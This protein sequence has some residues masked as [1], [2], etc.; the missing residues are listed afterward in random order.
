MT[1]VPIRE[2]HLFGLLAVG[3]SVTVLLHS[4]GQLAWAPSSLLG[5][6]F[7]YVGF[8]LLWLFA[9]AEFKPY[10]V[11]VWVNLE[12]LRDDFG[13]A[14]Q[15]A[16]GNEP[17]FNSFTF[18]ALTPGAFACSAHSSAESTAYYSTRL[19]FAGALPGGRPGWPGPH[20]FFESRNRG[21]VF[22]V[23]A[24]DDWWP[25]QSGRF[26]PEIPKTLT[27]AGYGWQ[28]VV[29]RVLPSG[30]LP[31]HLREREEPTRVFSLFSWRNKRW[32]TELRKGGW[33]V[34]ENDP[35]TITS[36]YLNVSYNSLG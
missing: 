21:L 31:D 2:L 19:G 11:K 33:T 8:G 32:M 3:A 17:A 27:G 34:D 12:A 23:R 7:T 20:F 25:A 29:L 15:A 30:Y 36:R 4:A 1:Q 14:D 13:S 26:A 16:L 10:V 6:G 28:A 9:L 35:C 18:T 22:G 24:G 5:L